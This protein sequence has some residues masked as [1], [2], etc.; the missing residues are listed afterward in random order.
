MLVD[1]VSHGKAPGHDAEVYV[2]TV[3]VAHDIGRRRSEWLWSLWLDQT[4]FVVFVGAGNYGFLHYVL[5]AASYSL[6]DF[7]SMVCVVQHGTTFMNITRVTL[8]SGPRNIH[9]ILDPGNRDG[10]T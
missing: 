8:H 6:H 4:I 10:G 7:L 9:F 3:A 5:A 1:V 2:S